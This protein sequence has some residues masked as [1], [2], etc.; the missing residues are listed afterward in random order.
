MKE[1]RQFDKKLAP[2]R[3]A[4]LRVEMLA[5]VKHASVA[6]TFLSYN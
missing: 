6:L 4:I 2:K 5:L 3:Q 1:E